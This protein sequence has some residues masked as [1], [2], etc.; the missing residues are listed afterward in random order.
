MAKATRWYDIITIKYIL[1]RPYSPFTGF[2]PFNHSSAGTAFCGRNPQ[3]HVCG[4]FAPMVVDGG[5]AGAGVYGLALR[6][7]HVAMG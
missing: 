7:L 1:V 5:C 2:D 4:T 6:S 3:R